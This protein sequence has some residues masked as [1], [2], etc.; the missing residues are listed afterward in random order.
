MEL[1]GGLQKA[2]NTPTVLG[3]ADIPRKGSV[4]LGP[5][6]TCEDARL[7]AGSVFRGLHGARKQAPLTPG[8][9]C[10]PSSK[11]GGDTVKV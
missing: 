10:L 9:L 7:S 6:V 2:E 11:A 3:F 1:S 4:A 5:G 8:A